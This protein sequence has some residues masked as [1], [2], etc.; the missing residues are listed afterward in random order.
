MVVTVQTAL[1][2]KHGGS[3]VQAAFAAVS[4]TANTTCFL[5]NFL[6]DGVSAKVGQSAGTGN[7][8]VLHSRVRMSLFW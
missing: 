1:L 7:W 2:G 4:T 6:V 8:R 3:P 5:F